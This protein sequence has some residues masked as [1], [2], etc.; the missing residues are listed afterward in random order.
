MSQMKQLVI[1]HFDIWTTADSGRKTNRGRVSVNAGDVYGI[2]KLRALI[3]EL[4]VRGKLVPQYANEEPVIELLKRIDA[5]KVKLVSEGVIR[6]DKPIANIKEMEVPYLL[7]ST[8]K[9]VRFGSISQHNSGKT[10]DNGRNSGVLHEYITTSN[11]YWGR[12]ELENVR[13]MPI[14]D[15]ELAK[16]SVKKHDLLICEGGEAGRAAVWPYEKEICFQNHIHRARFH[17][18]INPYFAFRF[19]EKLNATGEINKHRKGVAIS[20]MSGNALSDICFPLPPVAE[21]HRIVTKVDELMALCDLLEARHNKASEAHEKLISHLLGTLVQSQDVTEFNTNWQCIASHFH[22]LFT[23][24]FSIDTLKQTLLQLAVMGKLVPQDPTDEPASKLLNRIQIEKATL[25][26]EGKIKKTKPLP[27]IKNIEKP[28]N[29]PQS[30]AWAR[31][32]EIVE[33]TE[34]G[35]SNQTFDVQTGVPVLKMGDVQD[36]KIVLGN[37]KKVDENIEGLPHLYL[38]SGDLLYNRTN[39]AELVGKTGIYEGPQNSYTFASYLIRLRCVETL[40]SSSYLNL[41]M[42][43]P[44]FRK[45]QI[46]PHLK[47]Q[48]GQANVNGAIMKNMIIS[49]PSVKEQYRIVAKI[50][51]LMALCDQ[52]KNRIT[53]IKQC[54]KKLA[55]VLVENTVS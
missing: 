44:L 50:E 3:L 47:Q 49:F 51:E 36:G 5:E 55:D 14:R 7:P 46:D 23:T 15:E 43:T 6:K 10:L 42:N 21:Q 54:Q 22:T 11:L 30:W 45:T 35:I 31:I 26:A 24:E 9:W 27:P 29:L 16:C 34:Y 33:S 25:I 39:S 1:A 32:G 38:K 8:W 20:N 13:Q 37:K 48:C 18:D 4:A 2:K 41:V 12:F 17:C 19:F 53:G 52:L 28:F 40:F